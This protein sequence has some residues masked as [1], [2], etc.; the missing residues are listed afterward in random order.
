MG[1]RHRGWVNSAP[2]QPSGGSTLTGET[3]WHTHLLCELLQLY[4]LTVTWSVLE[5]EHVQALIVYPTRTLVLNG[6]TPIACGQLTGFQRQLIMAMLIY[7]LRSADD[8]LGPA[9]H[10]TTAVIW[11][12]QQWPLHERDELACWQ[13]CWR[14][15]QHMA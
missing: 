13:R 7:Y 11:R 12:Q 6:S 9:G 1:R 14:V 3:A 4:E 8:Y 10:T 2:P 15:A 5:N